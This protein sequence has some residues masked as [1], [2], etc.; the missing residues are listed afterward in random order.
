GRVDGARLESV[1]LAQA[2]FEDYAA[3]DGG[4]VDVAA[5]HGVLTWISPAAR[6]AAIGIVVQRLRPGGLFY[7]SYN[8]L[9]GWAPMEP[10]RQ[11]AL[12]VNQRSGGPSL[13]PL[14]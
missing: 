9:P 11:L 10:I 6:K 8:C 14:N 3:Q 5:M 13:E 1:A 2:S 12:T 4:E 7:V